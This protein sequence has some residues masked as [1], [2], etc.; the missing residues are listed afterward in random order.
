[1]LVYRLWSW[2]CNR[3]HD[4]MALV[5]RHCAPVGLPRSTLSLLIVSA[6]G[7]NLTTVYV[8]SHCH[9]RP[10]C[11]GIYNVAQTGWTCLSLFLATCTAVMVDTL[12][13][14]NLKISTWVMTPCQARYYGIG[15]GTWG[16]YRI[17]NHRVAALGKNTTKTPER[18]EAF[19]IA[20]AVIVLSWVP[21]T[22]E[23][24]WRH[25]CGHSCL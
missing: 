16:C 13:G 7:C 10:G 4:L 14:S 21:L 19:T 25:H 17:L 22:W 12:T 1:M 6:V 2:S 18:V 15:N 24:T 5:L 8:N 9:C 3:H 11:W 23:L 20:F